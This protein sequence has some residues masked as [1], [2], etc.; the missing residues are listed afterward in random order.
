MVQKDCWVTE[1]SNSR[2]TVLG[3]L[4][5]SL[6][7]LSACE[8]ALYEWPPAGD[9]PANATVPMTAQ[10]FKY[11]TR[12]LG[13]DDLRIN[14]EIFGRI[15]Y[16]DDVKIQ[17]PRANVLG[18]SEPME[19]QA[20]LV[21]GQRNCVAIR[22]TREEVFYAPVYLGRAI[23]PIY[24]R[25]GDILTLTPSISKAVMQVVLKNQHG[26]LYFEQK[27]V[28]YIFEIDQAP[29]YYQPE[30]SKDDIDTCYAMLSP[31]TPTF[32]EDW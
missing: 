12:L 2:A 32:A 22:F 25:E 7:A 11:Y 20:M 28:E 15:I 21:P 3:V 1:F 24:P 27:N 6:V 19:P 17:Q 5:L 14:K 31:K 23:F 4:A 9:P 30:V 29:I 8:M 13:S 18:I 26:D 10:S 16:V